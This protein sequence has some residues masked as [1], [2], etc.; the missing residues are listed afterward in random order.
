MSTTD[1]RVVSLKFDNQQFESGVK[2]S[3]GTLDRLKQ[4]LN[5]GG[6]AKG[7]DGLKTATKGFSMGNVAGAVEAVTSKFSI[8]GTIGD[9]VLRNLTNS[10]MNLG[11]NILTAIPRQ[12][13]EGGKRRAQN[14]EQA[15]FQLKG[16]M[17]NEYDWGKI[18]ENLDYAVS[19]TAYGLDAAAKVASQLKASNIDFGEDMKGAL[20]G[21]SGVAAMTNSS[22][23]D[24]G[25]IFTT[26]AGQGKLMTDQL[27]QFA[28]R[29][30]NVAAEL[31]K[32]YNVT[33]AELRDMV[34]K[35]KVDFK[36]FALAMDSAFGDHAT[37]ANETFEGAFSNIKASLSRM[38][39]KFATPIYD[40][41]RDV[42]NKLLP[43]MKGFEK[44]IAPIA[45]SFEKFASS[46]AKPLENGLE[47]ASNW[48][49]AYLEK[50][51]LIPAANDNAA[52]STDKA[53]KSLNDLNEI[54]QQV[55]GGKFGSGEGRRKALEELGLS[56]EEVQNKVN[57]LLGVSKR[58]EVDGSS[59]NKNVS[60]SAD[61]ASDA[62]ENL[63]NW[64]KKYITENAAA[65]DAA[66]ETAKSLE[67]LS[68]WERAHLKE[69]E[70]L[71][72]KTQTLLDKVSLTLAGFGAA[73]SIVTRVGKAFT[74]LVLKP[75]A[76]FAIPKILGAVLTLT[77]KIGGK[78]V[79]LNNSLSKSGAIEHFFWTIRDS[80]KA[81]G[82][83]FGEI[84]DKVSGMIDS[85]KQSA[86]FSRLVSAFDTL[87]GVIGDAF[88]KRIEKIGEAFGNF[89]NQLT[90]IPSSTIFDTIGKSVRNVMETLAIMFEHMAKLKDLPGVKHL[91]D[92]LGRLKEA[93]GGLVSS[94]L[95][96]IGGLLKKT[97]E[98]FDAFPKENFFTKIDKAIN[99]IADALANVIDVATG[100]TN[101]M[102]E[103]F[104]P[105]TNATI[106]VIGSIFG[107][108][109]S[110]VGIVSSLTGG[111]IEGFG[112]ALPRVF[113][114]VRTVIG[115]LFTSFK[116]L[117]SGVSRQDVTTAFGVAG[118]LI[119]LE[120]V[121]RKIFFFGN[122]VKRV[123]GKGGIKD[124]IRLFFSN[125][126]DLFDEK[127]GGF[128][129]VFDKFNNAFTTFQNGIKADV[130]KKTAISIAILAG[131]LFVLASIPVDKLGAAVVAIVILMQQMNTVVGTF[132][133]I[134]KTGGTE[135]FIS[136]GAG[137]TLI[138]I[139]VLILA[140]AAKKLANLSWEELAKGL[141]G[142]IGLIL[143]MASVSK[144]IDTQ[145]KGMISAAA[146][147]ILLGIALK[148]MVGSVAALGEMD[149]NA[150]AQGVL[151]IFALLAELSIVLLMMSDSKK[152]ISSALSLVIIGIA[153]K[154]F[155]D[156]IKF[157]GEMDINALAQGV[158]AIGALLLELS[159]AML[160]MSTAKG[161][162]ANAVA[163]VIIGKSLSD[164]IKAISDIGGMDLKTLVQ[165]LLGLGA[166]LIVLA[167]G[168]SAMTGSLVGAAAL[169][170]ITAALAL[171]VPVLKSLG[172]MSVGEIIKSLI[173]LAGVFVLLGVAGAVLGILSPLMIAAAAAMFLM[174]AAVALLGA[175]VLLL[176][177][178]LATLG[179]SAAAGVAGLM[180][181]IEAFILGLANSAA[182]IA[183]G[184]TIMV[185]ALLEGIKSVIPNLVNTGLE[186]VLALLTGILNNMGPIAATALLIILEF[187][188]IVTEMLPAIIQ[189]GVD[190]MVGFVNGLANGLR[191]NTDKIFQAIQNLFSSIIEF[192]LAALANLAEDI[193]VVGNKI[194]SALDE[195]RQSLADTYSVEEGEKTTEEYTSGMVRGAEKGKKDVEKSLGEVNDA[196]DKSGK[197]L[198]HSGTTHG[199]AYME[200]T[201]QGIED[202]SSE[203]SNAAEN[204]TF[205]ILDKIK[206]ASSGEGT[207]ISSDILDEITT[208]FQDGSTNM[209]PEVASYLEQM[210]GDANSEV[211]ATE[212]FTQLGY[213]ID[214]GTTGGIKEN[215]NEPAEAAGEMV[216]GVEDEAR[217]KLESHSPSRVFEEIG[218][219]VPDGMANGIKDRTPQVQSMATLMANTALIA[220]HAIAP[221]FSTPGRNAAMSYAN[222]ILSAVGAVRAAASSLGSSA[223]SGAGGVSLYSLG[224]DAA[225]GY[226]NGIKSKLKE[227]YNAGASI[228]KNAKQGAQDNQKSKSPS[229][230]FRGLGHDAMD[231]YILG[232]RD[233]IKDVGKVAATASQTGIDATKDSLKNMVDAISGKMDLDPTIKPVLDLSDIK[234]GASTIN[235][236][237]PNGS[238]G[239]G[240]AVA[241]NAPGATYRM[242]N[243]DVV[244]AINGLRDDLINNPQTINN[245]SMGNVSY[246][247]GSNVATAVRSLIRAAR[248]ERRV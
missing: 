55:I 173:T 14:I 47:A 104:A 207:K 88:T 65:A 20:R 49:Q 125:I 244:S 162:L 57:E 205:D 167:V 190:L 82:K 95:N 206:S 7:L 102:S 193:P 168:V 39:Q 154:Q 97:G 109:K 133:A 119:I 2:T 120:K 198:A 147:M 240:L 48:L 15:Q 67:G 18:S 16:L 37:K 230:V 99:F 189:T 223:R 13:I 150:L 60:D 236:L 143:A 24:I 182:A 107:I 203:A 32:S 6:A 43:L 63:S 185:N 36:T 26:I 113:N 98:Q 68:Q 128:L 222:G 212:L 56:Y 5:L 224:Q 153:L 92:S 130:L 89:K 10:A 248:T 76:S 245:Y 177:I 158:V 235:N 53:A 208:G 140:A 152:S 164:F 243:E 215:A 178:G 33:E 165:G 3:L 142:V 241:G 83:V 122:Y 204:S 131:A 118:L 41:L 149:T 116:N 59:A 112:N 101:A 231:G 151:A 66:N 69:S 214:S 70:S 233:K 188:G 170:V 156:S 209:S 200:N 141:T 42:F 34:T 232:F 94:G 175:G 229:K 225:K 90:S 73:F 180:F 246:D 23:E 64:E 29:G 114:N 91:A 61:E 174:G 85:I 161:S 19:G 127:N 194:A 239:L 183:E 17:G 27:N 210:L 136:I 74:Q 87:K 132:T 221:L 172:E 242:T 247:D 226:I 129:G 25:H 103:F 58:Y 71:G 146:A 45:A 216:G 123:F 138:A 148:V 179:A 108:L 139:A 93:I 124:D 211:D 227:A 51:G 80:G 46:I 77:S 135:K 199:K 160:M 78:L 126:N 44:L 238:V 28:G 219:S 12:I 115:N 50:V 9:Q 86:E 186:L 166:M 35:G 137:L 8:L 110:G 21:I 84:K 213:D 38:G 30:L 201:A 195:T 22:Y 121:R 196:V 169:V 96:V 157:L 111:F 62:Y 72:E 54:A 237:L 144:L 105:F 52:D 81:V 75:F 171:L 181:A 197:K 1:E 163:L 218:R 220:V 31:A 40:N 100:G 155:I 145:V 192:V 4:G 176:S 159:L 228:A 191:D 11:R 184:A 202:E 117:L 106:G 79:D 234:K 134:A 187:I 217:S